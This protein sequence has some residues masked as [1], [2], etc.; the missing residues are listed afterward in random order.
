MAPG[1]IP[2]IRPTGPLEK[3]QITIQAALA[4]GLSY[5]CPPRPGP[6]PKDSGRFVNT[7]LGK[8]LIG[9]DNEKFVQELFAGIRISQET[10]IEKMLNTDF[11]VTRDKGRKI[12]YKWI[13]RY[14]RIIYV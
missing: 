7:I 13:I 3:G 11:E 4:G 6:V 5:L 12:L 9:G 14:T 10:A 1:V 8:W 2:T